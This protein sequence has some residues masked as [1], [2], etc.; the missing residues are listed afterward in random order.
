MYSC[1]QHVHDLYPH[2]V[3][4][5]VGLDMQAVFRCDVAPLLAMVGAQLLASG[6][7]STARGLLTGLFAAASCIAASST[8]DSVFWGRLLWPEG[9]V[10]W[11]NVIL[12]RSALHTVQS[13][14]RHCS[15]AGP[16]PIA[17]PSA[18]TSGVPRGASCHG[19]GT[20]RQRYHVL[21]CHLFHFG[22]MVQQSTHAVAALH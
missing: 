2:Q 12:N 19:T 10:F 17:D 1:S 20:S 21:C 9:E 22:C 15:T 8:I 11:F 14:Y 18:V 3:A 13:W 4:R 5:A 16:L 6:R 7:I